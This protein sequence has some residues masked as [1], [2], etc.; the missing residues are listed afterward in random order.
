[1]TL[2]LS[3]SLRSCGRS[4][5]LCTLGGKARETS[6]TQDTIPKTPARRSPRL[7][8]SGST[9]EA[10][11]LKLTNLAHVVTARSLLN[12]VPSMLHMLR[13][14]C[15]PVPSLAESLFLDDE[16][17]RR[18]RHFG[19]EHRSW[20]MIHLTRLRR[21][22]VL[23]GRPFVLRQ[24]RAATRLALRACSSCSSC[25]SCN[26]FV[27]FQRYGVLTN[28]GHRIRVYTLAVRTKP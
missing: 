12:S 18:A 20:Y 26:Y 6:K 9:R 27:I 7:L 14:N 22:P 17:S 25:N 28:A 13:I 21:P 5:N 16:P 8:V 10:H 19:T 15:R 23:P 1:M 24:F 4:G 3:Q 2:A 11:T